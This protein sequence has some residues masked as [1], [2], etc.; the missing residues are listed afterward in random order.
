MVFE[1]SVPEKRAIKIY[2][3]TINSILELTQRQQDILVE[4]IKVDLS[5]TDKRRKDITDSLSRKQMIKETLINK[6]NL[7]RYIKTFKDNSILVSNGEGWIVNPSLL[8]ST[9][10]TT[11]EL[12]LT[13]KIKIED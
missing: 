8:P 2:V 11:K 4:L 9:F 10:N 1:T 7:S 12:E 6:N 5:W 13:F 3:K